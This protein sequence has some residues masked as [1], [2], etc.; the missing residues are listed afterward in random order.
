MEQRFQELN[1]VASVSLDY[2]AM[3]GIH[4][5]I[6]DDYG[7]IGFSY[8]CPECN[9]ENNF[10]DSDLGCQKCGFEEKYVDPEYWYDLEIK[11]P[12]NHRAWNVKK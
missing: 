11:K 8:K 4:L 3:K 7:I 2:K 12:V 1:Y 6:S 10:Q 9:H 5:P